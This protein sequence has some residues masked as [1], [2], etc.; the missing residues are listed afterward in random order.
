MVK[1]INPK[2]Q[3]FQG[4]A[5]PITQAIEA[6]AGETNRALQNFKAVAASR[7]IR[8]GVQDRN[9]GSLAAVPNGWVL[10][11]PSD[12]TVCIIPPVQQGSSGQLTENTT[13]S[14]KNK[15]LSANSYLIAAS[16]I[17]RVEDPGTGLVMSSQ[18][19]ISS[20]A[21][22]F[23]WTLLGPLNDRVWY[24]TDTN[25][26]RVTNPTNPT[27][28]PD[29]NPNCPDCPEVDP[30]TITVAFG[31][32]FISISSLK[33]ETCLRLG[34]IIPNILVVPGYTTSSTV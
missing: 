8:G 23:T 6:L 24:V 17:N 13:F 1:P 28:V 16:S 20:L 7:T 5:K 15:S 10:L 34:P 29:P 2:L 12:S 27:P 4:D 32:P 11:D 33:A 14:V 30:R 18:F 25:S 31:G 22:A 21:G 26:S 9:P 3:R 19:Q